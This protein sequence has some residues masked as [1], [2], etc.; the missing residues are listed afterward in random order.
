MKNAPLLLTSDTM[1]VQ[2]HI[3]PMGRTPHIKIHAFCETQ[4]LAVSIQKV[5]DDRRFRRAGTEISQGGIA[6]AIAYCTHHPTPDVLILESPATKSELLAA[7]GDLASVCDEKTKVIVVG[8][9]ND[10]TLYR[11]L[12]DS[13]IAEYLVTPVNP[14]AIMATIL[15]FFSET[16]AVRIGKVCAVVGCKGGTGASVLAQNLAAMMSQQGMPTM[17]ADLDLSFGTAA[18]NYNIDSPIGFAEQLPEADRLDAALLERLLFKHGPH[19]SVLPGPT[20][21]HICVEPDG[22]VIS[23]LIALAQSMFPH[24]LLDL[25]HTWSPMVRSVLESADDIILVAEP[26]LAGLRNARCLFDFFKATRPNDP[27]PRLVLNKVGLPKRK[28]ITPAQFAAALKIPIAGQ[29][30]FDPATFS[31]A[32]NAG[33]MIA[34]ASKH[35]PAVPVLQDLARQVLGLPSPKKRTHLRKLWRRAGTKE[36]AQ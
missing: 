34:E 32:A 28:E 5:K 2:P 16:S 35:A 20:A 11:E 1:V 26:D 21:A 12:M 33:Q 6:A 36:S 3:R 22:E 19:L 24:V 15:R 4:S 7:L 23:K 31:A 10:I 8:A 17:L 30:G 18:L 29:I 9:S 14:L 13:G 25:S 27:Q